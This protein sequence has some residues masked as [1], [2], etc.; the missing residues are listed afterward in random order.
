VTFN[1]QKCGIKAGFKK[2]LR[3]RISRRVSDE[4]FGQFFLEILDRAED[5]V[6]VPKLVG[7]GN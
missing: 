3:V 6:T 2:V 7:L 5:G 1:H 4:V